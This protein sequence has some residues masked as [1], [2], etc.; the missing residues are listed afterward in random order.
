MCTDQLAFG[1]LRACN[2]LGIKVPDDIAIVGHDDVENAQ[3]SIPSL[4]TV[5]VPKYKLGYSS[6][7][8]I[9][10]M[11]KNKDADLQYKKTV[12]PKLIIRESSC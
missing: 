7:E 1:L 2:D 8:T 3:F 5:R 10:R 6:A 12:T 11:I 4:T 9:I